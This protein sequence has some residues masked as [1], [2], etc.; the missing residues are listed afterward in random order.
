[1]PEETDTIDETTRIVVGSVWNR[2]KYTKPWKNN[3]CTD[4]SLS[5]CLSISSSDQ[6]VL[7]KGQV[8]NCKRRNLSCSSAE[9]RSSTA[10]SRTKVQFY[11]GLNRCG[12]FPC[13]A[14][15]TLSLA[16][17]QTLK[18]L[19]SS[20]GHRR[21]DLANWALSTSPNSPQGLNINFI[22]VFDHIRD[23]EIPITL[24]PFFYSIF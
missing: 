12:S 24:L 8:L 9:G 19:K 3:K 17:E 15:P 10:N 2:S 1:M 6:S 18:D 20:Q 23:P 4:T 7:P 16:S 5:T 11:Q 13:F 22:R 21:V 14:H